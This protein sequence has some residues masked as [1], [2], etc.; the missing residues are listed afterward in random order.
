M[1]QKIL[2]YTDG[3][4]S[5]NKAGWGFV[6]PHHGIRACGVVKREPTNNRAE[7]MAALKAMR[8]ACDM[9]AYEMMLKSDSMYVVNALSLWIPKWVRQNW[10]KGSNGKTV[11]NRDILEKIWEQM[12][13]IR[14]LPRH[15]EAHGSDLS[16]PDTYWNEY[17]D[18][19]AKRGASK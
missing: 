3:A 2:A 13:V 18:R 15:V 14:V 8:Y 1:P 4:C 6:F 5:N 10:V 11:E 7:L 17:A 16:D 12:K 9:H 19:L